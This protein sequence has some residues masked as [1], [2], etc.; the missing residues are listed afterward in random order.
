VTGTQGATGGIGAA[1]IIGSSGGSVT[2][3][4]TVYTGP[5]DQ[6]QTTL[7]NEGNVE[8]I[9]PTTLT[10]TH[11]ECFGPKP[12]AG[13]NDV[14][15]VRV[16]GASTS[17]TC[18]I[19]TGSSSAVSSSISLTITAGQLFDVQVANGNNAGNVYWGLG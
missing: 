3:G 2:G 9:A 19:P 6:V 14:F 13:T 11:F 5:S 12:T 10:F 17:A 15:T 1:Y 4:T 18:T 7:L 8:Q 16:N